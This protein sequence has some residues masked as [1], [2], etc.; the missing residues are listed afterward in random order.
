LKKQ[1]SFK[2]ISEY[3]TSLG[4]PEGLGG[5]EVCHAINGTMAKIL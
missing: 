5:S 4:Q 2:H 3:A 1:S